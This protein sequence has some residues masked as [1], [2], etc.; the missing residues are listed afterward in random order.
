MLNSEG[1]IF[2]VNFLKKPLLMTVVFACCFFIAEQHVSIAGAVADGAEVATDAFETVEPESGPS[3][4]ESGDFE[5]A[6][7]EPVD[8]ET[9]GYQLDTVTVTAQK[10][11]ENLQKVPGSI[12]A[13]TEGQVE[14]AGLEKTEDIAAYTPNLHIVEFG[15]VG[16]YTMRGITNT[17]LGDPSVGLYVDGIPYS[18]VFAYDTSLAEVER[19]EVLRGPQGTLYGKNS[20]AGV[21]NIITKKPTNNIWQ[22]KLNMGWGNYDSSSYLLAL[23]GPFQNDKLFFALTA[24]WMDRDGFLDNT[25]LETTLGQKKRFAGQ[26]KLRW[27]PKDDWDV[28]LSLAT[29]D[30]EIAGLT[31]KP[32][33][34]SS[35]DTV[36]WDEN[37]KAQ[38]H[39]DNLALSLVRETSAYTMTAIT[40]MREWE[41]NPWK[42]DCDLSSV[43]Y[44][45]QFSF[46]EVRQFSQE[47]RLQSPGNTGKWRWLTGLYYEH[48]ELDVNEGGIFGSSAGEKAGITDRQVIEKVDAS[49][50]V[51]GQ[52]SY[53]LNEKATVTLGNRFQQDRRKIEHD[54]RFE[55]NGE[56]TS[57]VSYQATDTFTSALPKLSWDYQLDPHKMTYVSIGKGYKSGGFS[58][59]ADAAADAKF[60]AEDSW[61]YEAGL[62]SSWLQNRLS[63]NLAVFWIATDDY[64][65]A[66]T[67]HDKNSVTVRNAAQ[68]VSKG[69][70]LEVS[71]RP[72]PGLDLSAAIGYVNAKFDRFIDPDDG[73]DYGGKKICLVPAYTYSLAAQYRTK[74]GLFTRVEWQMIGPMYWDEANSLRQD[75]YRLVNLKMGYESANYQFY[76]YGKNLF[77]AEYYSG[78]LDMHALGYTG[79]LGDPRT[80]G[81]VVSRRF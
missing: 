3:S 43:H 54:H 37:G 41:M 10:R 63:A 74:Q 31:V 51:F 69:V 27:L 64:Q 58:R 50:A 71:A 65:V 21:I 55:E 42:M 78:T 47:L 30:F 24:S 18:D 48:K 20:Q 67:I 9:G 49:T 17:S 57:S 60:E 61:N 7:C 8:S 14:D 29:D 40:T 46:D 25:Y 23:D 12:T 5:A 79:M 16:Y 75:A 6:D 77:D 45:H 81:F 15:P 11:E 13:L 39:S 34:L 2:K 19:I 4:S 26:A 70:E 1:E 52:I 32:L 22:G 80:Y 33:E 68:A 35:A 38:T 66:H 62:K 56:L 59:A 53:A 44:Y 36:A 76:V 72:L 73:T 28:T